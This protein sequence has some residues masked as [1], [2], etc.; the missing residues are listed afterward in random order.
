MKQRYSKKPG[1]HKRIA[2]ERINELFRQ[3]SIAFPENK[4]MADRYVQLARKIAMKYK[5]VIPS[6]L[7][8][9]FCGHCYSYMK[10]GANQRIRIR[11][12]VKIY[13]CME[14]KKVSRVPY[15]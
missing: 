9:R 14:C 4:K 15:R 6:G 5:T 12:G 11:N 7:K 13:F 1:E 10:P 8:R 2:R 3:A